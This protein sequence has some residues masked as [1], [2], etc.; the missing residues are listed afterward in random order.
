MSARGSELLHAYDRADA[1]RRALGAKPE[2]LRQPGEV[3]AAWAK[4][5]AAHREWQASAQQADTEA[6]R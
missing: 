1:E 2:C 4:A 6:G 5:E 3:E